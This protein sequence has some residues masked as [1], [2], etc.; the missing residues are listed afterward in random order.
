MLKNGM[1]NRIFLSMFCAKQQRLV[2]G[3]IY[4]KEDVGGT[5]LKRLDAALIF[6][7]LSQGC[8]STAAI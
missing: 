7:A 2:F 4:V 6:E 1:K 8:V 3:A 5:G